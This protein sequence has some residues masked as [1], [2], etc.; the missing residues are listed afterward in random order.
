[1]FEQPF[2]RAAFWQRC[3]ELLGPYFWSFLIG[4]TSGAAVVGIGAYFVMHRILARG[5]GA[6]RGQAP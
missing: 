3:V 1:V 5:T 4:P 6:L 2:Y